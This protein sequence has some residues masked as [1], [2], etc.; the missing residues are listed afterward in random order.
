MP[1]IP[2]ADMHPVRLL[3]LLQM[4][5]FMGSDERVHCRRLIDLLSNFMSTTNLIK[6]SSPF[7][8]HFI[9]DHA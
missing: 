1:A 7:T 6:Q 5:R 2:L 9:A 3:L 8:L 4:A